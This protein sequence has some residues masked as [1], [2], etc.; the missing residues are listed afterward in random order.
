MNINVFSEMTRKKAAFQQSNVLAICST[1]LRGSPVTLS[2]R[3]AFLYPQ[4]KA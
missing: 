1:P 2:A 4:A 3:T